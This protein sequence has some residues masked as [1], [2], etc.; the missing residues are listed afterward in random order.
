MPSVQD[1]RHW[2]Q[3][4]LGIAALGAGALGAGYLG[5]KYL[6]SGHLTS[7]L[8]DSIM[9]K[10][11]EG[12]PQARTFT[13]EEQIRSDRNT[14]TPEEQIRS[15]RNMATIN[16]PGAATQGTVLSSGTHYRPSDIQHRS[17]NDMSG[18][19]NQLKDYSSKSYDSDFY[20]PRQTQTSV[21]E[22]VAYG[23]GMAVDTGS[24]LAGAAK[25]LK[26]SSV[27]SLG[28][29]ANGAFR[30]ANP[31]VAANLADNDTLGNA[32]A[33]TYGLS[34]EAGR[35]MSAAHAGGAATV[36]S[37]V[38]IPRTALAVAAKTIPGAALAVAANVIPT[39]ARVAIASGAGSQIRE[40][41]LNDMS[42][43]KL[44]LFQKFLQEHNID[45]LRQL[46]QLDPDLENDPF[47][48]S[49]SNNGNVQNM[50]RN[51][52]NRL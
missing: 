34:D 28:G 41:T 3:K 50:I 32:F 7:G 38:P 51:V 18:L 25:W 48:K 16:N 22:D 9:G 1:K 4:P 43:N 12:T 33:E 44:H 35:R 36:G 52:Y 46:K 13:P 24:L 30:I 14:F 15:D 11:P 2:Y 29:Y 27:P 17:V 45:G 39:A 47:V 23:T 31:L 42:G 8:M 49:V 5:D 21:P 19:L 26:P 6:N 37:L 40:N 10:K 20:T